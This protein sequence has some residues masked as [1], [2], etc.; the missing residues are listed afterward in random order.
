VCY[1][2]E[3]CAVDVREAAAEAGQYGPDGLIVHG[4]FLEGCGWDAQ[5]GQLCESDPKVRKSRGRCACVGAWRVWGAWGVG[6]AAVCWYMGC[7]AC[8]GRA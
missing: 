1:D 4:M 5:A 7:C 2:F 6:R 8:G 3:M